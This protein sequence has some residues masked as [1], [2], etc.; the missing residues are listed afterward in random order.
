MFSSFGLDHTPFD[1]RL[2]AFRIPIRVHPTF[3]IFSLLLTWEPDHPEAIL[4]WLMCLFVSIVV[5]ELGHAL[6]AEAFGWTSHIVLYWGG[7]L[8]ISERYSNRTPWKEI[9]VAAAGPLAGFCLLGLVEILFLYV[10]PIAFIQQYPLILLVYAFL[11]W[12]NLW[13]GLINL[14]PVLPLDGGRIMIAVFEMFRLRNPL[15]TASRVGLVVASAAA[16]LFF[17]T[18]PKS[19]F[20][21]FL[22]A[23]IALQNFATLQ[24][25][26]D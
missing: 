13:W 11:H 18:N 20:P 5:H 19:L 7:G 8:A 14:L 21:V 9:A 1:I 15:A 4:I 25:T 12:I 23:A 26:Q 6:V 17:V 10:V 3:W 24:Q 16:A 22:F 2:V